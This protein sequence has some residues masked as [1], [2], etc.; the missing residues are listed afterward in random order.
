M[1]SRFKSEGV[2]ERIHPPCSKLRFFAGDSFFEP[3]VASGDVRLSSFGAGVRA[4]QV[5]VARGG[6]ASLARLGGASLAPFGDEVG[7]GAS[8]APFGDEVGGDASL[9]PFGDD[10]GGGASLAPVGAALPWAL[11]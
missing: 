8:L 11:R 10:G 5:L 9:A 6:D 7:G 4:R 3:F 2:H 1:G